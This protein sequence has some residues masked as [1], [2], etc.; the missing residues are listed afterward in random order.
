MPPSTRM[1]AQELRAS[2]GLSGIFG[3]R[4]LGMFVILPVFAIYAEHLPGGDNLTLVGIAIGAYGLTQAILQIPFGA[5]SDRYGRKP[6]IYV[7]LLIFAAGSFVAA[8]APNIYIVILGRVLQGAGA[9]SAAVMA[10]AADLTRDEHRTKAMAMIGSTIGATFALSLVASPWLNKVIGVPGIF[11]LTGVLALAA[12]A[13]VYAVVPDVAGEPQDERRIPARRGLDGLWQVLRDAQ[14]ARL[15][16]GVFALHAV[17]MAL[18]IA[19]PFTLRDA[20]LALDQHWKVYL[21][22]M[23]GS[24]VLML[25][26]VLKSGRPAHARIAFIMSVAL[27][28]LTQ[29][30]MPWLSGSVWP[31][32]LYLLLFFTAFNILEA[33]LPSLVSRMAPAGIKGTAIGIFSSLQFFGTFLGAAAGGYLYG[34]WGA[35]GIVILDVALLVIWLGL[36]FGMR[37]PAVYSTRTYALPELDRGRADGLLAELRAVPGV[38]EAL[39]MA[40]E[41]MLYLKVDSAGFDEQNVLKLIAG[42]T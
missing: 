32:A 1:S 22:V 25:P 13:V 41:H 34:H 18:F 19:V 14:L 27:L 23:L 21:P 6:V 31:I 40:G 15:Y 16:Y 7:G 10:M 37:V 5:W 30:A 17:L 12:M 39:V 42:E 26:A 2:I 8:A 36:A 29:L 4:M 20:G 9:I 24:F 3:L 38:H 11:A 33:S 28:L 35:A